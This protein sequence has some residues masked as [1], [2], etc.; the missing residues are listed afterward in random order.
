MT[1][2]VLLAGMA[3]AL[4][5][6][7]A[8]YGLAALLG[9]IVLLGVLASPAFGVYTLVAIAPITS[10]FQKGFPIHGVNVS[11]G[12]TGVIAVIVLTTVPA[13]ARIRW[14][15]FDLA[16]LT[17]CSGWLMLGLVDAH[18]LGTPLG[19]LSS[20][21]PLIGPFQFLLLLRAV[22]AGLR[23]PAQRA[24]A[25]AVLFVASVP[26]DLLAYLQQARVG[27][28]NRLITRMT[29]STILQS[30]EYHFFSRATGPF[31]H[32]TPFAGYLLILLLVGLACLLFDVPVALPRRVFGG[33]LLMAAV[34]LILTA[35]LSALIGC[36]IGATALGILAGR[37]TQALRWL[38]LAV[39]VVGVVG[40]QYLSKRLG[41]EFGTSAGTTSPSVVPQTIA[42]RFQVWTGQYLPAIRARPVLGWGQALP[43]YVSWPFTESQYVTYAMAGGIPLLLLFLVELVALFIHGRSGVTLGRRTMSPEDRTTL[44]GLGSA[45]IV[46]A[47]I[48]ALV[49]LIF[50]YLTSGGLPDPLM[51]V[52]GVLSA[53]M[54][55]PSFDLSEPRSRGPEP[56]SL[57][58]TNGSA[59]PVS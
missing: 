39:A 3:G 50:P 31:N 27:A 42:Y 57:A 54:N 16:L 45:V 49:C 59:A 25:L 9:A 2:S 11:E 5:T 28:V 52:V 10:G 41:A 20:L 15:I 6:Y 36:L 19:G 37:G 18:E 7:H 44:T 13:G 4:A 29:G 35:E 30:R 33:L 56:A 48:V 46:L 32:W 1:A 23:T 55:W 38:L 21:D 34:S 24:R 40:G 51:I 43:T 12:L 14:R 8:A 53:T 58:T 22:S 47:P 26:T 17:L